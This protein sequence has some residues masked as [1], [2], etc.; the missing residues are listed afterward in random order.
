MRRSTDRILTTHVGSLPD[1]D[2]LREGE[3]GYEAILKRS[4]AGVVAQQRDLGIDVINEG[5]YTKGGDWLSFVESR[6]G[7]FEEGERPEGELP[8][9][10]RGKTAGSSLTSTSMRPGSEASSTAIK[11]GPAVRTGYV[12]GRSHIPDRTNWLARYRC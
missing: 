1:P 6:F 7:G 4:V 10:M 11:S 3:P 2:D 12:Q 8:L 9:V 5:E